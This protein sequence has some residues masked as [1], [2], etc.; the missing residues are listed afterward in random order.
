MNGVTNI[1]FV[2]RSLASLLYPSASTA[3]RSPGATIHGDIS[4]GAVQYWVSA[5]N[6]KV[7]LTNNMT[8]QPEFMGWL[9]LY[10]WKNKKDNPIQ[11]FAI[12]GSIAH[13]QIRGLPN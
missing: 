13:R 5:F 1:D 10:P 6:G 4:G 8:N 12:G 9:R 11:A 7:I 2:E 3:Y